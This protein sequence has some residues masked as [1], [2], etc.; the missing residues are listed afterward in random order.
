MSRPLRLHA[1]GLLHHIFSRGN[2]KECMFE[3]DEDYNFFLELLS[4]TAERFRVQCVAYCLLGNH[5]HLLAIPH[6]AKIS[7]L[8]QQLNSRYCQRF[9]RRHGRVGHVVQ[10]RF[11]SPIIEDGVYART[12]LRYVALNPVAA[13]LAKSAEEWRWSSYRAAIGLETVPSFLSL[14]PVWSAFETID[15][16]VGRARF[17]EF[18]RA[19]S[20]GELAQSLLHGSEQLAIDV[21]PQIK[22]HQTNVDF[23]YAHRFAARPPLATLLAGCGDRVSAQDAAH[24]AYYHHGYSLAELG[25]VLGR[26]PSVISRW[27]KRAAERH[28]PAPGGSSG[29]SLL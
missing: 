1:P 8:M 12:A 14:E 15:P 13:D 29:V 9:N 16:G 6:E 28:P 17:A 11:G 2:N 26:H 18:V 19:G 3:D 21:A 23:I 4:T 27:I 20:K 22:P 24:A 7:R 25:R 10:G 5:Y